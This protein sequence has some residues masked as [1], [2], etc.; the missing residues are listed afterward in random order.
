MLHFL[1]HKAQHLI[2]TVG[3][4]A[5]SASLASADDKAKTETKKATKAESSEKAVAKVPAA[6]KGKLIEDKKGKIQD[7]KISGN[8]D[9]YVLYHSASW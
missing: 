8:L 6:L 7:A 5:I 3:V 1:S 9:Y 4:F 2:T